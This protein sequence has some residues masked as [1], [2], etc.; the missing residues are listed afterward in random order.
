MGAASADRSVSK[1]G[2]ASARF[3]AALSYE[4][5][6]RAAAVIMAVVTRCLRSGNEYAGYD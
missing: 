4:E 6:E 5:C 1:R 3:T 2:R